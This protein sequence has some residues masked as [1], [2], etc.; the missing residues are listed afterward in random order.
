[1]R[2]KEQALQ[3]LVEMSRALGDP[4]KEYVLLGEGNTST[5]VD[6]QTFLVKASGQQLGSIGPE[7]FVEVRYQPV[8]E[9]L[10]AGEMSDQQLHDGLM[11]AR[12]DPQ[13]SYKPSVET[14]FHAFLLTLPGVEFVGHTH[15]AAVNSLLCAQGARELVYGC[16]FPDQIVYCGLHPVYLAYVDPGLLL[17]RVMRE[18]IEGYMHEHGEVPKV[19][20][21]QNHG[22]VAI[23]KNA[24][25]VLD[26]TAMYVK[27]AKVL[28]GT[29]AF[30]GPRFFTSAQAERLHT[31]PDEEYR[32]QVAEH[33]QRQ[34]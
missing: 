26:I 2:T 31:R 14:L 17:A 30:G 22:F 13:G 29:H 32:R 4:M 33:W 25:E 21:M 15:P 7:G 5:R 6:D 27:T 23:G 18:H 3:S 8:L 28:M 1:V 12:V 20:L 10:E 16:L 19:I 24:R 9:M 11:A 34:E